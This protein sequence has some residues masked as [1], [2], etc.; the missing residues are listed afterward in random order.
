MRA[1]IERERGEQKIKELMGAVEVPWEMKESV[2]AELREML[3]RGEHELVLPEGV[4]IR[5]RHRPAVGH[6]DR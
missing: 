1:R 6:N 5:E 3:A 4:R 2:K